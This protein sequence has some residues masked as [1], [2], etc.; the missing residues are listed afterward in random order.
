MQ[1]PLDKGMKTFPGVKADSNAN[2][3]PAFILAMASSCVIIPNVIDCSE[4]VVWSRSRQLTHCENLAQ[5]FL[6]CVS[7]EIHSS[8]VNGMRGV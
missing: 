2:P 1:A 6:F 5:H 7:P 8:R 3:T 4:L